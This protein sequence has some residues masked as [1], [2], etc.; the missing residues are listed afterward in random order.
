MKANAA[1]TIRFQV[2][3]LPELGTSVGISGTAK[4]QEVGGPA[5]IGFLGGGGIYYSLKG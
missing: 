1:E 2:E 3:E 5:C 4:Q